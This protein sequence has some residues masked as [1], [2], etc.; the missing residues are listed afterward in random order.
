[1]KRKEK[2][3][4]ITNFK[5]GI[6]PKTFTLSGI[7]RKLQPHFDTI[8]VVNSKSK[9]HTKQIIKTH[10]DDFDIFAGYGGDGTIN[11]I[12]KRLINT[13]KILSIL[14]GGSGN[15]LA[16]NLKIPPFLNLA[17]D[18]LINGHDVPIDMGIINKRK[19]LNISGMGYD[20]YIAGRFEENAKV[21]GLLPYF[22]YALEGYFKMPPFR[23]VIQIEGPQNIEI[24][25]EVFLMALANFK[26]YGGKTII[27]PDASPSDKLLD[28]CIL[29]KPNLVPN[30][31]RFWNLWAGKIS[32]YPFY[33]SYK[34]K[35]ATIKS[36]DGPVPVHYDGEFSSL[37]TDEFIVRVVPHCLKIRVPRKVRFETET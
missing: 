37:K 25:E 13:D 5:S 18:T 27:A 29:N 28:L 36:L 9:Q 12:A 26:E 33:K 2:V 35:K 17:F 15:G 3:I 24:E 31:F 16:N 14:P 19:F 22:Y 4:I 30:I 1:M 8:F 6:F 20:G 32:K 7:Y 10:L 34:F 23:A 11:S 21:R